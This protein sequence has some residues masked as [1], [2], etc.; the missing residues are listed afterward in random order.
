VTPIE[1]QFKGKGFYFPA[2]QAAVFIADGRK[3]VRV[4]HGSILLFCSKPE[5]QLRGEGRSSNIV[6]Y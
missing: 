5:V 6:A 4:G 1:G 3:F 2:I